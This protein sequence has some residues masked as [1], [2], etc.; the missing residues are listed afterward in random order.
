MTSRQ[1]RKADERVADILRCIDRIAS[2]E[3]QLVTAE[4]DGDDRAADIALDA[5]FYNLV[6]IGEAVN[7][8]PREFIDTEP[9]I[10][11]RDIVD[12]RNFL[13]HDYHRVRSE[14]VCAAIDGP[15]EDLGAACRHLRGP[16]RQTA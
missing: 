12:M 1:R 11:W 7:A 14:L 2:A 15:L 4:G 16:G 10:P 13:A 8:L 9:D 6:V 5:V 3:I